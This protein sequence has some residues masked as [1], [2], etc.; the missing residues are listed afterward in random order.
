MLAA[1]GAATDSDTSRL[2]PSATRQRYR[3][4]TMSFLHQPGAGGLRERV[5][6]ATLALLLMAC[7]NTTDTPPC[8]KVNEPACIMSCGSLESGVV[9]P[10]C[11]R[12]NWE[13]PANSERL[14]DC[15]PESCR[16][17][18]RYCCDTINGAVT[19]RVCGD[20]GLAGDCPSGSEPR[21]WRECWP[22]DGVEGCAVRD[23]TACAKLDDQCHSTESCATDCTCIAGDDGLV[24]SCNFSLCPP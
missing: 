23:R 16:G 18:M 10:E 24:W 11:N 9:I 14:S 1:S 5:Q 21:Q 19:D 4:P 15:A 20:D 12:G 17:A 7:G 6:S 22:A 3:P 8:E 2:L 13:C